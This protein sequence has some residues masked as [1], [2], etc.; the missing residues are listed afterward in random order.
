[1]SQSPFWSCSSGKSPIIYFFVCHFKCLHPSLAV[2]ISAV[3]ILSLCRR[4]WDVSRL[5]FLRP[6]SQRCSPWLCEAWT[7]PEWETRATQRN[8][9]LSFALRLAVAMTTED[10]RWAEIHGVM[11]CFSGLTVCVFVRE[12]EKIR[13]R[14]G[15]QWY[16]YL[17]L[18]QNIAQA[19]LFKIV[20][21]KHTMNVQDSIVYL[22]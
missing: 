5:P 16:S 20:I 19:W 21:R 15:V 10:F 2:N 18:V 8:P 12:E 13:T 7:G 3:L 1:M 9:S 4:G 11:W 6:I 17:T 22:L 14:W